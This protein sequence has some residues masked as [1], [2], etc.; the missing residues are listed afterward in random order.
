MTNL[1]V[2]V[3]ILITNILKSIKIMK[4]KIRNTAGLKGSRSIR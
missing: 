1:N 4:P 2:V 3:I